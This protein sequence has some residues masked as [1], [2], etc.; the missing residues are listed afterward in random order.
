MDKYE[1]FALVFI[2]IAAIPILYLLYFVGR[3]VV[4]AVSDYRNRDQSAKDAESFRRM[5][6]SVNAIPLAEARVEAEALL[7]NGSGFRYS[8]LPA[9]K[10]APGLSDDLQEFFAKHGEISVEEGEVW[11]CG[12][13]V[14]AYEYDK[15][16]LRLGQD[17]EHTHVAVKANQ[18]AV[19]VVADDVPRAEA[20]EEEF[21]SIYHYL[22]FVDRRGRLFD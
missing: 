7:Q 19:F 12:S 3:I 11:I 15:A 2:V 4:A 16:F 8:T 14:K 1:I 6:E 9:G 22:L 20:V 13:E 5:V 18:P 21:P 10:P 17:G